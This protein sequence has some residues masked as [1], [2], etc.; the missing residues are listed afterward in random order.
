MS[1]WRI[2]FKAVVS[3][4]SMRGERNK[5]HSDTSH[6]ENQPL[7][8]SQHILFYSGIGRFTFLVVSLFYAED[9]V[10]WCDYIA[11]YIIFGD[12]VCIG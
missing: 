9:L 2:I 12:D 11:K 8:K 4:I 7:R 6:E 3:K 10:D 5:T 1:L